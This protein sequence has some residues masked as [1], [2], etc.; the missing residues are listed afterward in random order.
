MARKKKKSHVKG[1]LL[2]VVGLIAAIVFMP[3]TIVLIMGMIPTIVAAV[4]DRSGKGTKA[5]TVGSMNVAGCSPFLIDLWT[6]GHTPEMA[7]SIITDPR[8]I[9]VIYSAAGIGYLI[10]W[11]VAGIVGTIMVERGKIRIKDI[12]K[13][14]AALVE[15]WGKEVTGDIPLDAYGFPLEDD[16]GPQKKAQNK[17]KS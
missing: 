15:R 4:I 1:Q 8:T 9:I 17:E 14:Q 10:N 12:K 11:A 16:H 3:T 5:L 2:G 7:V 6:K 13:R